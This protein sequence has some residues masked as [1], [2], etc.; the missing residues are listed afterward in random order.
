MPDAG[1]P[2]IDHPRTQNARDGSCGVRGGV[3]SDSPAQKDAMPDRFR[4]PQCPS[5]LTRLWSG[6]NGERKISPDKRQKGGA[7]AGPGL[8]GR[9][10]LAFLHRVYR[11]VR[12]YGADIVVQIVSS[13]TSTKREFTRDFLNTTIGVHGRSRAHIDHRGALIY[14]PFKCMARAMVC[15]P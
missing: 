8:K 13:K 1:M 9:S 6:V 14:T 3:A 15:V 4:V 7:A 11:P 10:L 12:T 5:Q 2:H